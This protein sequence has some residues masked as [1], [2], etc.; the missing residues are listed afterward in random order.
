MKTYI[1]K[2]KNKKRR[3]S[4]TVLTNCLTFSEAARQS[5]LERNRLG[6]DWYIEG[7][8]EKR[9]KNKATEKFH[10]RRFNKTSW[11]RRKDSFC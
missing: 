4:K 3:G 8:H 11:R 10:A 9:R 2:L 1:I 7:V 6:Y 5:Y